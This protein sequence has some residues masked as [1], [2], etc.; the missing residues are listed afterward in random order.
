MKTRRSSVTT[1]SRNLGSDSEYWYP[2]PYRE[3]FRA[4]SILPQSLPSGKAAAISS[5]TNG[6]S[7]LARYPMPRSI[8]SRL[9][10]TIALTLL[11]RI[12]QAARSPPGLPDPSPARYKTG[13][14][15]DA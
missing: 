15:M 12:A 9:V 7:P 10:I 8:R 11:P 13:L 2:G 6:P 3:G 5:F 14:S 1:R 4:A